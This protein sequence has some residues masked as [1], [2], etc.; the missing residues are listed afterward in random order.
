MRRIAIDPKEGFH[1][2][3]GTDRS[4]AATMVIEP[5]EAEGG[6]DNAHDGDQWLYV[7]SGRGRATVEGQAQELSP[8]TLLLIAAGERHEVR[9]EG[10]EPL[11]TVNIY[12][13]PQYD[14]DGEELA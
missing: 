8:G 11:R 2:L 14:E 12:T 1:V 6:P 7:V 4:Q 5:G 9:A 13:P 3:A 10:D